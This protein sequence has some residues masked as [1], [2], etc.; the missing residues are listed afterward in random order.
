MTPTPTYRPV[1]APFAELGVALVPT[2]REWWRGGLLD[3]I[4]RRPRRSTAQPSH[5]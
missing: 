1:S 4:S 5:I 3:A 2:P